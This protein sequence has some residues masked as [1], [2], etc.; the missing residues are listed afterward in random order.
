MEVAQPVKT[1]NL[2]HSLTP[3][4]GRQ[5][6]VDE[7]RRLLISRRLITLTGPGGAGKTRLA[8][9]VV[10]GLQ[11]EFPDGV[12]LVELADMLE[13]VL[14]PQA[15]AGAMGIR[16]SPGQAVLDALLI[17]LNGRS[18]LLLLD[19]CEHLLEACAHLAATLLQRCPNLRLL[20][21][22]RQA[23]GLP[24]EIVRPMLPLALPSPHAR[25]SLAEMRR[26]EAVALFLDRASALVP[27]FDL[28]ED[29]V[30]AVGQICRLLDGMPLAIELAAAR[31]P[32][33][34]PVQIAARLDNSLRW[35]TAGPH[36]LQPRH[37]TM[38]AAIDW[39][40]GL[41]SPPEQQMWRCLSVFR[42]S[43]SLA[44]AEAVCGTMDDEPATDRRSL[45]PDF[46]DLLTQLVQKS[47][48][49]VIREPGEARY[50]LLEP[51]RQYAAEQLE[52][53]GETAVFRQRHYDY[54]LTWVEQHEA[55]L[56]GPEQMSV[57]A[58]FDARYANLRAALSW[59]LGQSQGAAAG[60]R[61][62]VA[63][64]RFWIFRN[65]FSEGRRWL[66]Q[67]LNQPGAEAPT[68]A[69]GQA[70]L[71]ACTLAWY[72]GDIPAARRTIDENHAIMSAHDYNGPWGLA[73]SLMML[74]QT[75][76]FQG[77]LETAVYHLQESVARFRRYDDRWGLALALDCLGGTLTQAGDLADARRALEES[78]SLWRA[79]DDQWGMAL[80]NL[81]FF[82]LAVDAKDEA[83]AQA[84]HAENESRYEALGYI[85]HLSSM[86]L[87]LGEIALHQAKY[88][89]AVEQYERCL[90]LSRQINNEARQG[91]AL[92]GL[93]AA[94][95]GLGHR[96]E[97]ANFCHAG[98][99]LLE[100]QQ[101]PDTMMHELTRFASVAGHVGYL[102]LA[103]RLR[104]LAQLLQRTTTELGGS[105][106]QSDAFPVILAELQG[107]TQMQP[108]RETAVATPFDLTPRELE[109]LRLVAEGLTDP[110]VAE[111]LIISKRTV[112][113]H[114]HTIYSKLGVNTRAAA[115]R[116]ALENDLLNNQ[117]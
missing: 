37:Q 96:E 15:V 105:A 106:E 94:H 25:L 49:L 40:Y 78:R 95:L 3:F 7:I 88:A 6:E 52:T 110:Q 32:V 85:W 117:P 29:N 83:V 56:R 18:T 72:Q 24:G 9:E 76:R 61:L 36:L 45:T 14:V 38:R 64:G 71:F 31:V 47:L 87:G 92:I 12:W 113:A 66:E 21:T 81:L 34:D 90:A 50:Q 63:L 20:V 48:V 111:R 114:L 89:V 109:I 55:R 116:I 103:E 5:Q 102:R 65:L 22:S 59:S 1:A 42:G 62:A 67:A 33:L 13:P 104:A 74:G 30:T 46:L 23:L 39:S 44:A 60:L 53:M 97:A 69:R 17:A 80:S 98:L 10:T 11:S 115:T 86:C 99:L 2:P 68:V 51:L 41:L 77:E 43:F 79:L 70:L 57:L 91:M 73:Y 100:R 28:S 108:V 54:Y 75:V 84:L 101:R 27:D 93:G 8:L 58:Q 82:L 16:E 107:L 35:L 4:I 112:S 19:N 26:V